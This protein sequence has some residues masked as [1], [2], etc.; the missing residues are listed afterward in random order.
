[1]HLNGGSCKFCNG[2]I[3]LNPDGMAQFMHEEDC[4]FR[5]A[6]YG[7]EELGDEMMDGYQE[8]DVA[9]DNDDREGDAEVEELR[10]KLEKAEYRHRKRLRPNVSLE[11]LGKIKE[12]L[13]RA[14]SMSAQ[15]PPPTD[16]ARGRPSK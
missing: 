3:I 14:G 8:E 10:R 6:E 16:L 9:P 15:A 13:R 4:V 5:N 2:Q 11:W 1:M 12:I 7:S